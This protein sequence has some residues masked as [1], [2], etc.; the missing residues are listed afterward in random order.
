MSFRVIGNRLQ[1]IALLS[2]SVFNGQPTVF[3]WLKKG[4]VFL[5]L[6]LLQLSLFDARIIHFYND[7][8]VNWC[9]PKKNSVTAFFPGLFAAEEQKQE[10]G[11]APLGGIWSL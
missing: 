10:K 3:V 11:P 5:Y 1:Q 9:K 2:L 6:C 7:K 8:I 4:R